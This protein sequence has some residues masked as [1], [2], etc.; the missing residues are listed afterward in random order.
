[1]DQQ[2]RKIEMTH[3]FQTL[4]IYQISSFAFR[5]K[6]ISSDS[7]TSDVSWAYSM[8]F[9]SGYREGFGGI[10]RYSTSPSSISMTLFIEGRSL[11]FN[12]I[13]HSATIIIFFVVFE[14]PSSISSI[15]TTFFPLL[16]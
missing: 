8:G 5:S 15:S 16:N 9:S 7:M 10:G 4:T 3:K 1:S 12:C 6:L 2:K 14:S 13:H 11:G